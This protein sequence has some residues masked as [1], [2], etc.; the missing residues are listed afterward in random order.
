MCNSR[1]FARV[2]ETLWQTGDQVADVGLPPKSRLDL[3]EAWGA[4]GEQLRRVAGA[5]RLQAAWPFRKS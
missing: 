1:L 4:A 3:V 5:L 2:Y